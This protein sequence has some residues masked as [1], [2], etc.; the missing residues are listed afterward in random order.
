MPRLN[1]IPQGCA[2]NPRCIAA[3]DRC[4]RERPIA[5]RIGAS[6]VACWL[7]DEQ[8]RQSNLRAVVAR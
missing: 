3:F 7:D 6:E 4:R 8:L 2:F 5:R 1:A